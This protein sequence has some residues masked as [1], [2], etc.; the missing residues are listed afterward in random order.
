[1]HRA[2]VKELIDQ[3]VSSITLAKLRL[4]AFD[5]VRHKEQ[6]LMLAERIPNRADRQ[7]N[8]LAS[9]KVSSNIPYS[10]FLPEP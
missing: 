6:A 3:G 7:L 2:K 8:Q 9:L 5:K 4:D 10:P 1:M